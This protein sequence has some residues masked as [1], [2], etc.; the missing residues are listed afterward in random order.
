MD[1]VSAVAMAIILDYRSN[2][3]TVGDRRRMGFDDVGSPLRRR[4]PQEGGPAT[5]AGGWPP[6]TLPSR[7]SREEPIWLASIRTIRMWMADGPPLDRGRKAV[8]R[9]LK[10]VSPAG[11]CLE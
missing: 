3:A 1:G 9:C 5:R 11:R 7:E 10:S 6:T 2:D 4:S 8:G